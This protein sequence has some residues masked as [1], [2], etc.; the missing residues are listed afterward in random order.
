[1]KQVCRTARRKEIGL[2]EEARSCPMGCNIDRS[3]ELGLEFF[4]DLEWEKSCA[5][6]TGQGLFIDVCISAQIYVQML[7]CYYHSHRLI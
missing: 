6:A 2:V 1:M 7:R 4:G 3:P 5:N